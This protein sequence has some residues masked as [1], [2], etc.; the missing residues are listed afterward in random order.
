MS[1]RLLRNFKMKLVGV[2]LSPFVRR[3]AIALNCYGIA[4]ERVEASVVDGRATI[5]QYNGLVRVPSL[6]LDDG[7]VLID[8]QQILAD[9]D[10]QVAQDKRLCPALEKSQ[11]PYGQMLALLT[12]ALEKMVATFYETR[13][14]PAEKIWPEWA[15]Q[16]GDQAVGGIV[17][18]EAGA[19]DDV[20][21]GGFL[22]EQRLTHADIVA[23]IAYETLSG[24]LP[25]RVNVT[26]LPKLAALASRLGPTAAFASTRP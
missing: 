17:A 14:R 23:V 9:L 25:D 13:R 1:A 5:A 16:C 22:F 4:F 21:L 15:A 18:A 19:S 2:Y 12:G 10:R 26:V 6:I 11:R 7:T 3:V 24:A 20:L 8:S